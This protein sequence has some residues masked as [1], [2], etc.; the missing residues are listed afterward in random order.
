MALTINITMNSHVFWHLTDYCDQE[1][2]YCPSRY[3]GGDTAQPPDVYLSIIKK[4]Q[5]SR[6]KYADKIIWQLS[7]GEPLSIPSIGQMLAKIKEHP[8]YV[9]IETAG[10]NSWFDY[11]SI[12]EYIDQ[13]TFTYH[14]WQNSSVA[15]YIIDFCQTN[16]KVIKIKVPFAPGKVREQLSLISDL[17]NRGISTRGLPMFNDARSSNGLIDGYTNSEINLMFGRPEDWVEPPPPPVDPNAPDPAWKD[18]NQDDGSSKYLGWQCHA[19]VDYLYISHKGW[20][21]GSDCGARS[22]GNVYEPDWMPMD[23]PFACPMFF[24]RSEK[25]KQ[26]IRINKYPS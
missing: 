5:D 4:I 21:S 17:T 10:G 11:M 18:P 3:S 16:N 24:C 26:R 15:E 20:A 14:H 9:K 19:G 7:G 2:D 1:C 25:D 6:Y 13:I 23:Q 12:Q 22:G 8:S